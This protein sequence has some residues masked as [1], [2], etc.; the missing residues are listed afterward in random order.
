MVGRGRRT[1]ACDV[2]V[3]VYVCGSHPSFRYIA[4]SPHPRD[5][6]GV[7]NS[8]STYTV[9][10]LVRSINGVLCCHRTTGA[11]NSREG[12]NY[13]YLLAYQFPLPPPYL[14]PF[15]S[16]FHYNATIYQLAEFGASV[17]YMAVNAKAQQA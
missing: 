3:P 4:R 14:V 1:V 6:N 16:I 15:I 5:R 17:P 10:C 13:V 2:S 11:Q 12:W 8:I 9:W 7:S